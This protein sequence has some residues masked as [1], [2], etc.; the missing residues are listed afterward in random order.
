MD[1]ELENHVQRI[2]RYLRE[3]A[4]IP[5]LG[6]GVNTCGR[7]DAEFHLG[8]RLPSGR[9]LAQHLAATAGYPD[10]NHAD[11]ARVAQYFAVTEGDG[12]LYRELRKVFGGHFDP[13]PLHILL[14][15]I[16]QVVRQNPQPVYPLIVTTNYDDAL[17]RAFTRPASRSTWSSTS[18]AA[19]ASGQVPATSRP[20]GAVEIERPRTSTSELS[21]AASDR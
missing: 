10:L 6:A 14:A 20:D 16:P 12:E 3:G 21:L 7:V 19:R 15:H 5:F 1:P 11:L 2:A 18:P 8:E 17:E 9:E 4:L 13:T